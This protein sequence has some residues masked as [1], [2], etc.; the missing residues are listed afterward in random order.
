MSRDLAQ[1]LTPGVL[2]GYALRAFKYGGCGALALAL[3][4]AT[5]WP[6]VAITDHYN[7][8]EDGQAG[9]GSALHWTVRHPDGRLIDIDGAHDPEDL[10][11]QYHGDADDGQAAAGTSSREDVVEWY[12]ECQGEPIPVSLAVSFVSPLLE[13]IGKSD[14]LSR[15]GGL[16]SE[17]GENDALASELGREPKMRPR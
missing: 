10:V 9:G 2:D 15:E 13:A 12:I 7:V 4:D 1:H 8:F 14:A 17:L 11:E 16:L 6:I 5:G 3:H